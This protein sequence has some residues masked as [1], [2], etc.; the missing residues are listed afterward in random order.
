MLWC[1]RVAAQVAASQEGFGS[2]KWVSYDL[3]FQLAFSYIYIPVP[4]ESF[5]TGRPD[6]ECF[7][8]IR[9]L[10]I[11]GTLLSRHRF[12]N[13]FSSLVWKPDLSP[14]RSFCAHFLVNNQ[15]LTP[16][17]QEAR[18]FSVIAK[19]HWPFP[20]PLE[21]RKS[22]T[23]FLQVHKPLSFPLMTWPR[24]RFRHE[25]RRPFPSDQEFW[26]LYDVNVTCMFCRQC[27]FLYACFIALVE[28]WCPLY[29]SHVV[30]RPHSVQRILW[31]LVI[32]PDSSPIHP[33]FSW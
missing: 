22:I 17:S 4:T 23:L 32:S 2:G 31:R 11:P 18:P 7:R 6:P 13:V 24:W 1:S 19:D 12:P 33:A 9:T 20:F 8:Q 5:P 28:S 21:V 29:P 14:A 26:F 25:H 27:R 15:A 30:L 10:Y 3:L 16:V